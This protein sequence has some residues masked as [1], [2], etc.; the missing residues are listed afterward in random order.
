M[1]DLPVW[2]FTIFGFNSNCIIY[3]FIESELDPNH[4]WVKP[5]SQVYFLCYHLMS[6]L[7]MYFDEL[8]LASIKYKFLFLFFPLR[9]S[10]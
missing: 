10:N 8:Q 9:F 5:F 2:N 4:L 7:S 6:H 1:L 3:S